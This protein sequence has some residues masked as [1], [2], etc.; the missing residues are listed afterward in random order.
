MTAISPEAF[1]AQPPDP[2]EDLETD[3]RHSPTVNPQ[4]SI[5][6]SLERLVGHFESTTFDGGLADSVREDLLD[7]EAKHDTLR[8]LLEEIEAI[9][10]PSTSK[11]ANQVREAI[12]RW[13]DPEVPAAAEGGEEP[14]GEPE[15]PSHDAPV[16][17]W[18]EF[19]LL[20]GHT[21]ETVTGMNRSQI[22]SMLGIEQPGTTV[23]P[24]VVHA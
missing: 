16:E 11:L 23:T 5:A 10:K 1:M 18:R 8:A 24:S 3:L 17:E 14:S 19:A 21:P 7:L 6:L 2:D 12:G 20:H 15:H 4:V 22:R 9:I 13:R